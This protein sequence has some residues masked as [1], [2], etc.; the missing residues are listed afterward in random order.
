MSSQ[1]KQELLQKCCEKQTAATKCYQCGSPS[2]PEFTTSIFWQEYSFC[3]GWCQHDVEIGIRKSWKQ[4]IR[5][6]KLGKK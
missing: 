4:S 3:S 2:D 6:S 5:K 1:L